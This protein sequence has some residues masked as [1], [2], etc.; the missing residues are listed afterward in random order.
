M[1]INGKVY[2]KVLFYTGIKKEDISNKE[3]LIYNADNS[4]LELSQSL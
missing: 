1:A 2:L 3:R 4:T